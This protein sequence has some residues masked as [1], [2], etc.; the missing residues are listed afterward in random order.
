MLA[1]CILVEDTAAPSKEELQQKLTDITETSQLAYAD[2]SKSPRSIRS[3]AYIRFLPDKISDYL[4]KSVI[5][6][7][8]EYFNQHNGVVPKAVVRA[9]LS[10]ATGFGGGGGSTLTQQ[11]VKQQILSKRNY[12]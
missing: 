4:P 1:I 7:E 10:E 2:G 5:A 12:F 3:D 11:L 9:L 8:D 6:A